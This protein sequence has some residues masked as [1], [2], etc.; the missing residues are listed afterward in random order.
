VQAVR[1]RSQ[2]GLSEE[3]GGVQVRRH[4]LIRK[5]EDELAWISRRLAQERL[6]ALEKASGEKP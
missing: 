3:A 5:L 6:E 2:R 1:V 4:V